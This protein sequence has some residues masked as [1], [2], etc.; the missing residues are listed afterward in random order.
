MR[1]TTAMGAP[2]PALAFTQGTG[3]DPFDTLPLVDWE[4]VTVLG[5]V[6]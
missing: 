4:F 6:K 1:L 3:P 5:A 2:V